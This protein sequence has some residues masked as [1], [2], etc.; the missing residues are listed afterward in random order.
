LQ[1]QQHSDSTAQQQQ[2]QQQQTAVGWQHAGD[3]QHSGSSWRPALATHV[4]AG[5]QGVQRCWALI[6]INAAGMA[7]ADVCMAVWWIGRFLLF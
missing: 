3:G 7:A 2:Q 5:V 6:R 4:D 1:Q